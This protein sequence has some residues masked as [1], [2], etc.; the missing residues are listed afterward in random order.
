MSAPQSYVNWIN[1]HLG[2]NPRGQA[3]SNALSDFLVDDLQRFCPELSAH[4]ASGEV[5]PVR[6][7]DVQTRV[8][9]RNVDLVFRDKAGMARLAVEHKTIMTAHGKAR[10]N[11]YGD[12]IAYCNHMH[13]HRRECIAAAT[14]IIN[15]SPGYENPDVFAKGLV[16]PRFDMRK[17]VVDTAKIFT[18]V[19]LRSV[20][21][22]PNDEPEALA[23]LIVDYD[24]QKPAKLVTSDLAPQRD[25]PNSYDG[26]L[27]RI[28]DFYRKRFSAL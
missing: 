6:N 25:S 23:V 14:V 1:T 3:N 7:A 8:A 5:T 13:N 24:G 10:W 4:T 17:T 27:S 11:R 15:C 20:P 21:D 12:V 16:R 22:E 2:F 9:L 26:F 18:S 19:P 28:C